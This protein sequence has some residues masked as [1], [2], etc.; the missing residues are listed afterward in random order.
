MPKVR[1]IYNPGVAMVYVIK[2]T[3]TGETATAATCG[4]K[5]VDFKPWRSPKGTP[6]GQEFFKMKLGSKKDG[7]KSITFLN[8]SMQN[9]CLSDDGEWEFTGLRPDGGTI[10]K[11]TDPRA[12][13]QKSTI[14]YAQPSKKVK[15]TI[16]KVENNKLNVN[17]NQ[18]HATIENE[19]FVDMTE[20]NK[21]LN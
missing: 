19:E 9:S 3:R 14:E 16:E 7:F 12:V 13:K 11:L 6:K 4:I 2:N 18:I 15:A 17:K 20:M 5:D 8:S 10:P 21:I 1:T